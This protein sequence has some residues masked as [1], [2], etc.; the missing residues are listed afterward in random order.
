MN[1]T[2]V[3]ELIAQVEQRRRF[4]YSEGRVIDGDFMSAILRTLRALR[5]DRERLDWCLAH[6]ARITPLS[7]FKW[8]SDGVIRDLPVNGIDIDSARA[9]VDAAMAAES[10]RG[11]AA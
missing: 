10:S 9:A 2:D 6:A 7:E 1:E 3:D 11:D 4:D 5:K 8:M